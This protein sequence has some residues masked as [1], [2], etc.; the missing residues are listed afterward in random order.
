MEPQR[1][2]HSSSIGAAGK[3]DGVEDAEPVC[4]LDRPS[5]EQVGDDAD[6]EAFHGGD[7]ALKG[8]LEG[9]RGL[10]EGEKEG[11]TW[12]IVSI[13]DWGERP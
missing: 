1:E 7:E 10:Q 2:V 4:N 6:G 9:S 5:E 8:G 13:F 11:V 3:E 12:Q